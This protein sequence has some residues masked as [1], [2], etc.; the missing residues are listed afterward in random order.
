MK[1]ELERTYPHCP[2]AVWAALTDARAI[3]QWWVETDFEPIPG[4]AFFLQDQPQG[5]WDGRVTGE[6]LE[7]VPERK[8]R[9]SWRGGGHVTEVTYE[10]TPTG[11]GG[12]RLRLLHTGFAGMRGIFLRTMLRFGW[13]SFVKKILPGMAAHIEGTGLDTPFPSPSKRDRLAA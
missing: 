9:F 1:I 5:G 11:D 7:V 2:A 13:G 3:R 8:I 12:T 4:R 6:V 10:L